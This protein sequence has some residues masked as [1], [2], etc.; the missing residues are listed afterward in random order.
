[1]L[2]RGSAHLLLLC[3]LPAAGTCPL[4]SCSTQS[5]PWTASVHRYQRFSPHCSPRDGVW[6]PWREDAGSHWG[7]DQVLLGEGPGATGAVSLDG[8]GVGVEFT[9]WGELAAV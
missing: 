9:V 2:H 4:E 7:P 1:M 3:F 8:V 5:G 6:G